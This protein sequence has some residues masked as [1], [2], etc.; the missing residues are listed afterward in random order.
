M[1][2]KSKL[3][4]TL[5]P[6]LEWMNGDVQ[7]DQA[8]LTFNNGDKLEDFHNIII[9]LKQESKLS[10]ENVCPTVFIYH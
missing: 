9:R 10:G 3:I 4:H 7:Y 6:H 2:F 1:L 5:S 8:T